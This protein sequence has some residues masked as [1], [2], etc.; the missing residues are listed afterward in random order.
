MKR[1]EDFGTN[2]NNGFNR[3]YCYY[4]YKDGKFTEPELTL[5]QQIERV[6]NL[7]MDQ[8]GMTEKQAIRMALEIVP[9]LKRWHK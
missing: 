6:A 7:S 4:C 8:L 9:Q 1:D 3:E 5:R 2:L